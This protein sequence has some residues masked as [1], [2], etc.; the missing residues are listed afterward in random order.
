MIC[1]NILLIK[2]FTNLGSFSLRT[3][4]SFQVLLY[5]T[6]NSIWYYLFVDSEVVAS[7]AINT[8]YSIQHNS[9][10][11]TQLNGSKYCYVSQTIKLNINHLFTQ[12]NDQT[13][14]S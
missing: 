13:I 4:K 2:F 10:V 11:C 1:K 9:F 3:V 14:L 5:N 8:N 7:I 12:L 6:Y